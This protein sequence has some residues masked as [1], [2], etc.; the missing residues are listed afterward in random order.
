MAILT[1]VIFAKKFTEINAQP[2]IFNKDLIRH[3]INPP[4]DFSLDLFIL[5]ISKIKNYEIIEFPVIYKKRIS[6]VS[7][8]G[9]SLIG[10]IRLSYR[11]IK[12]IIELRF[13]VLK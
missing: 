2:K 6:G 13:N 8:G 11:A 1:S 9:D 12:Y 3:F 5:Y 4:K 7:K 10:K